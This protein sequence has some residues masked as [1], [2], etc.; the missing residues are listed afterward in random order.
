MKNMRTA[1]GLVCAA[2]LST[3][4]VPSAVAADGAPAP[5]TIPAPPAGQGQ[6]VF[7][8][9]GSL[10]GAA[11][12]CG[13]NIGAERISAL[14]RGKYFVLNLAPGAYEFNA[15]SEA[16]DVLNLEVE[17]GEVSFVKCTIRMGL[18][19]GRPNLAPSNAGEFAAKRSSLKYIDSDDAGPRVTPDPGVSG[20]TP[21]STPVA[22]ETPNPAPATSAA[23]SA[24]EAAP[25]Q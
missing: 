18:M 20:S 24:S 12:G 2:I 3:A 8:R 17:A 13:V 16:K 7:W 10:G 14:G 21:A 22:V 5:A 4:V 1:A 9:P 15:K 19:V 11:I 25:A 6:I 23:P